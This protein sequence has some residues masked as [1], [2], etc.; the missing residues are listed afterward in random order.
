[1]NGRDGSNDISATL[2]QANNCVNSQCQPNSAFKDF[3]P[4]NTDSSKILK[5]DTEYRSQQRHN[6]HTVDT[7]PSSSYANKPPRRMKSNIIKSYETHNEVEDEEEDGKGIYQHQQ[8][9]HEEEQEEEEIKAD[10]KTRDLMHTYHPK[11]NI[12][13]DNNIQFTAVTTS[14]DS[15]TVLHVV[16][17]SNSNTSSKSK[18]VGAKLNELGYGL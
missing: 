5:S 6:E 2:E 12:C 1:M 15:S 7:I 17:P 10:G 13:V 3:T 18:S 4:L 14:E 8:H 11:E 9:Q 16:K